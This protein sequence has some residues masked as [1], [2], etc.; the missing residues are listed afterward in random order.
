VQTI[1]FTKPT[2]KYMTM[3]KEETK[4]ENIN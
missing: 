3:L 1:G 4:K 2:G